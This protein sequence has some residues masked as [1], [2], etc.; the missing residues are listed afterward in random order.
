M[1]PAEC[2]ATA[3]RVD[4][5]STAH[6]WLAD[7]RPIAISLGEPLANDALASAC[8]ALHPPAN[9][10]PLRVELVVCTRRR[11]NEYAI[12]DLAKYGPSFLQI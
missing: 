9:V 8:L 6:Y 7:G 12:D 5:S 4:L 1:A 2:A 3:V 10:H 11:G